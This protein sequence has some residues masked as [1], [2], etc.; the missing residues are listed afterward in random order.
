MRNFKRGQGG[1]KGGQGAA[2]GK[3]KGGYGGMMGGQ[4]GIKSRGQGGTMAGQGGMMG[5]YGG[6]MGGQGGIGSQG[7]MMGGQGDMM[8]GQGDM[9]RGQGDMMRGQGNM[10]GGQGS[11]MGG[12]G[13]MMGGQGNMM[14][15]QGN[16][17]GGQGG[18]M[19]G[20]TGMNMM[21]EQSF[22]SGGSNQMADSRQTAFVEL[23]Q[24]QSEVIEKLA[25]RVGI[26]NEVNTG[27]GPRH[28]G[29]RGRGG[30]SM[31]SPRGDAMAMRGDGPRGP[32]SGSFRG[33]GGGPRGQFQGGPRGPGPFQGGPRGSFHGGPRGPGPFQGGPRG[34]FQG[35]NEM[36]DRKF[37][38]TCQIYLDTMKKNVPSNEDKLSGFCVICS[39]Q[40]KNN[41]G[42]FNH[43]RN[44]MH[45]RQEARIAEMP[46]KIRRQIDKVVNELYA[47]RE[48]HKYLMY[49]SVCEEKLSV[50]YS[51]HKNMITHTTKAKAVRAGCQICKSGPMKTYKQFKEHCYT[52]T[53][54]Q[55]ADKLD[56]KMEEAV[57]VK[58]L[59]PFQDGVVYVSKHI[60]PILGFYCV[61]CR[62]FLRDEAEMEIHLQ[63]E[64]H[65]NHVKDEHYNKRKSDKIDWGDYTP[66]AEE[67]EE[68]EAD[69]TNGSAA[70]EAAMTEEEGKEAKE[71]EDME[72]M[73]QEW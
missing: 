10:M 67:E 25:S 18:M 55:E 42:F 44:E 51:D 6:M 20:Q 48:K 5:G 29:P 68:E 46:E 73:E 9:M 43:R 19:G 22:G 60:E 53:H 17:M 72:T 40:S 1:R 7:G 36:N 8:R 63:L 12:Q 11:M 59:P 38:K 2:M 65:F 4:G 34:P 56:K 47:V 61:L 71:E 27:A 24:K 54:I 50:P 70:N 66:V 15:G 14:G 3:S 32:M 39:H 28:M 21:T 45:L 41:Q 33:M 37:L 35:G 16:M 58:D 49:C 52:E 64:R 30:P 69:K 57:D 26:S 62:K 13:S 31:M 23:I